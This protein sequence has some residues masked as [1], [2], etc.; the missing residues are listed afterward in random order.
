MLPRMSWRMKSAHCWR[1]GLFLVA[2][3]K[4]YLCDKSVI[5]VCAYDKIAL[6]AL[7]RAESVDDE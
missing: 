6:P 1:L 7:V 2:W 4:V 5:S 3:D